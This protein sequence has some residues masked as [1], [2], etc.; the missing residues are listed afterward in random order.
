MEIIHKE[1]SYEVMGA[2]FDVFNEIGYG[3]KEKIYQKAL[4]QVLKQK[5][6]SFDE[7]IKT[8]LYMKEE[9]V[10]IYFLDFL[11]ENKIVLEIKSRTNFRAA[12]L[13]QA[14]AYLNSLN[15]QL[16]ILA[17]FTPSGV[18]YRRILNIN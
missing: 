7:Q 3:H 16:A 12:D 14:K 6:I 13:R 1:L 10:G 11:I 4:S 17:T 18:K 9:V 2:L 5:K 8:D 15:L